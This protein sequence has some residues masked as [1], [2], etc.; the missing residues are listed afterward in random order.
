MSKQSSVRSSVLTKA[1]ILGVG[2]VCV[3]FIGWPGSDTRTSVERPSSFAALSISG[4]LTKPRSIHVPARAVEVHSL[5][6]DMN[7]GQVAALRKLPGIG[8]VLA[9]RIVEY[10]ETHGLFHTV[11]D[12]KAVPGIGDV[13][14]ERLR[15]LVTVTQEER[16]G[17]PLGS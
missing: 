8:G 16:H 15:P 10:R 4:H 12:L 3:A 6:V 14:I 13:R 17:R 9:Q 1:G 2:I 11:D 7:Q 5:R